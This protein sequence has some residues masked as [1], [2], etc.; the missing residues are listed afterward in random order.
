[1]AVQG[2]FTLREGF[3]EYT[4]NKPSV[5]LI[6]DEEWVLQGI[7]RNLRKGNYKI[8]TALNGAEGVAR[9]Q[10]NH[11]DL[12]ITDLLMP[13][14]DGIQVL[15][16]AKELDPSAR[17]MI[18][19]GHGSLYSAIDAL[20][21]GAV[22]Y[23][24]KPCSKTELLKRVE[25]CFSNF[26][27]H[28]ESRKHEDKKTGARSPLSIEQ[29]NIRILIVDN[30]PDS[31]SR[32]TRVLNPAGFKTFPANN[33]NEA[34]EKLLSVRPHIAL[35]DIWHGEKD[36]FQLVSEFQKLRPEMVNLVMTPLAE[37]SATITA[38]KKG[39]YACLIKPFSTDE[40]L[41][42]LDH[43]MEKLYLESENK[44]LR[45]LLAKT[46]EIFGNLENKDSRPET[47]PEASWEKQIRTI[48]KIQKDIE[49]KKHERIDSFL[50]KLSLSIRE[51]EIAILLFN[52]L[53]PNQLADGLF[54]SLNTVRNHMK[55]IYRKTRIN[56]RKELSELLQKV[57]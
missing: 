15:R 27:E 23:L 56:S 55:S 19:T 20:R 21:A 9:L 3:M 26:K 45:N 39:A 35:V 30:D 14:M 31:I 16:K 53:L 57:V 11:Y 29:G 4:A 5:L 34:L 38:V 48:E 17:V 18:L 8:D 50:R 33:R 43:C 2:I 13:G 54:I 25:R 51:R 44:T 24:L 28:Q 40:L 22:D 7:L 42:S 47:I 41:A 32:L 6:D 52:G 1:M 37:K 46:Y 10:K 36:H 49:S 12:V